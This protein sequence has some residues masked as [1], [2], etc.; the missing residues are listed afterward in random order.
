VDAYDQAVVPDDGLDPIRGQL[1]RLH[2]PLPSGVGSEGVAGQW[3][4][5]LGGTP[6]PIAG[7]DG[8]AGRAHL[9]AAP[10]PPSPAALPL[11]DGQAPTGEA[12]PV[13]QGGA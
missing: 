10:T 4:Y 2:Q 13:P 8:G 9:Q 5:V 3:V 1:S 7:P 11:S 12:D 6:K